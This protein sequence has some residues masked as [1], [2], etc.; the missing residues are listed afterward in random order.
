MAGG[1]NRG[2]EKPAGYQRTPGAPSFIL[3]HGDSD[4]PTGDRLIDGPRGG[5]QRLKTRS[6]ITFWMLLQQ[7]VGYLTGRG[8]KRKYFGGGLYV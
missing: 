4:F 2:D 7:R 3:S 5:E 1:V 6:Y 8:I